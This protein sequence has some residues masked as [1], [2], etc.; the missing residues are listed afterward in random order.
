MHKKILKTAMLIGCSM[1]LMGCDRVVDLTENESKLISEYAASMLLKYDLNYT[2]RIK[3]GEEAE[4]ERESEV[5]TQEVISTETTSEEVLAEGEMESV[6]SDDE[7]T[8]A[9]VGNEKDIAKIVGMNGVS[10]TYKDY[11][12]TKQYPAQN[13]DGKFIYLEASEGYQ[14]MVLHFDVLNTSKSKKNISMMNKDID[15][16][17]VC[18]GNKAA[19]PMLTILMEDLATFE[20]NLNPEE[21]Q[22]AVLVF[23][24]ADNMK[25]ALET[26][27]LKIH[28]NGTD[29]VI[30]ILD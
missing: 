10:I 5:T 7:T 4:Q 1:M 3:E 16:R 14:L 8:A 29:N 6:S 13:E 22:D 30:G 11:E 15:Y 26:I 12:I 17:I 20:T 25:D 2:D 27:D 28:F 24:I 21:N 23:Q 18:N 9:I 19:D